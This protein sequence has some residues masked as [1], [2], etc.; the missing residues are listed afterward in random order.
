MS[1]I[2]ITNFN[3][4]SAPGRIYFQ[5]YSLTPT[6]AVTVLTHLTASGGPPLQSSSLENKNPPRATLQSYI[7]Y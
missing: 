5:L 6:D 2:F 3:F 1:I 4:K 7:S